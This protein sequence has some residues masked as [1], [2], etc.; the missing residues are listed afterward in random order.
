MPS[1]ELVNHA[2]HPD[3]WHDVRAPGG[4][5]WWYFDA[6]DAATDTQIVAIFLYAAIYRALSARAQG[7][8]S[9]DDVLVKRGPARI[10]GTSGEGG[11]GA[12]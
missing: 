2:A 9:A 8:G 3:G 11:D 12:A 7:V 1:I 4:Y 5:E 10:T 6:E